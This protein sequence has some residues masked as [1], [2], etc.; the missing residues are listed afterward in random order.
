M[1]HILLSLLA[2][3]VIYY[4]ITKYSNKCIVLNPVCSGIKCIKNK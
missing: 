4:Y 1:K 3:Y 2:L